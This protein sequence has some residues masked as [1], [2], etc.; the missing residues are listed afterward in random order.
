[1]VWIKTGN[2]KFK[3]QM[4]TTGIENNGRTEITNGLKQGDL[5]VTSGAYLINSEYMLRN[6]NNSME[7]MDMS[8]MKM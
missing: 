5:V 6:G 3:S 8:K 2:N 1:M 4:V 7:G